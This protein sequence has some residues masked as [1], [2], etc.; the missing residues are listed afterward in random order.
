MPQA[1]F[2]EVIGFGYFYI[3]AI[4]DNKLKIYSFFL[5]VEELNDLFIKY[6]LFRIKYDLLF[7]FIVLGEREN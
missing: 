5:Y 6:D 7:G 3:I 2:L 4:F 1:D